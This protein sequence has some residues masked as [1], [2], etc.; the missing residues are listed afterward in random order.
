MSVRIKSNLGGFDR[1]LQ[2][3]AERGLK[4]G[5]QFYHSQLKLV[6]NTAGPS[7]RRL[8][9]KSKKP[10][11]KKGIVSRALS[12][13]RKA[14]KKRVNSYAKKLGLSKPTQKTPRAPKIQNRASLPGEPPRKRTGFGQRGIVRE[15]DGLTARVGVT[16]NAIYMYYLELGT[17]RIA[18]RPWIISTLKKHRTLIG[19]LMATGGRA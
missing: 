7:P 8:K 1:L 2:T 12:A 14:V 17:S 6:V 18:K 15:F 16:A 10:K 11:K 4:R 5:V 13:V 9:K 19:K 3:R